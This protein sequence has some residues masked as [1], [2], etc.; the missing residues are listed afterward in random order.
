MIHPWHDIP[1]GDDAPREVRA[2]IEVPGGDTT[3]YEL[4]PELGIIS[5][6]RVLHPPIP[7]PTNYGFLPQTL[8]DDGDPIDVLVMMQNSVIPLSVLRARPIGIFKMKDNG[9]TDDKLICVHVD[10][11]MY[12]DYKEVS[13][14]PRYERDELKW[15]FNSYKDAMQKGVDVED[16]QGKE[17]AHESIERCRKLYRE[18]FGDR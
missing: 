11:P 5:V 9:E 8:D 4:D 1:L 13:D 14:L 17:A 15:F 7:Y 18:K 2:V 16:F 6:D 3:K 10:D 12:S